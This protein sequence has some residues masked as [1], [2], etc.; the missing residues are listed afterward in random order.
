MG[1]SKQNKCLH[2]FLSRKKSKLHLNYEMLNWAGILSVFK[3]DC[4]FGWLVIYKLA[5][6]TL[7]YNEKCEDN[8]FSSSAS[9][10]F[11]ILK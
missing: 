2:L 3:I 10:V 1:S 4:V 11:K 5:G 8:Y 6:F 9:I 7:V